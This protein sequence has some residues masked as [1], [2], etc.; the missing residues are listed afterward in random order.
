VI[1]VA[2]C[3]ESQVDL[4]PDKETKYKQYVCTTRLFENCR[5]KQFDHASARGFAFGGRVGILEVW[6]GWTLAPVGLTSSEL[7]IFST[8]RIHKSTE[9]PS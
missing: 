1:A 3:W 6:A 5:V 2:R 4:G 7:Q 9:I 8:S